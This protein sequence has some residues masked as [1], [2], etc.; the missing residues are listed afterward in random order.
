MKLKHR[1]LIAIGLAVSCASPSTFALESGQYHV[2]KKEFVGPEKALQK[3][4][5]DIMYGPLMSLMVSRDE[6]DY[7]VYDQESG[8]LT[9]YTNSSTRKYRIDEEQAQFSKVHRKT[10]TLKDL[11]DTYFTIQEDFE[12]GTFFNIKMEKL[13][14]ISPR[15]T[16]LKKEK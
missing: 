12:A 7:A 4:D 16:F 11:G 8:D 15:T 6:I 14:D 13:E 2:T 10:E 3:L 9:L 5:A 1:T